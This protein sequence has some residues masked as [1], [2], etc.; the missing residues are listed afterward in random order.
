MSAV[1]KRIIII[2]SI[3][4]GVLAIVGG[5]V[6]VMMSK[7]SAVVARSDRLD[8][9]TIR[10]VEKEGDDYVLSFTYIPDAIGY[11]VCEYNPDTNERHTQTYKGD[12]VIYAGEYVK[13]RITDFLFNT[14]TEADYRDY[15]FTATAKYS[16]QVFN[17]K[18][19]AAY[20]YKNQLKL[21]TPTIKDIDPSATSMKWD[22][23]E[24]ATSYNIY[25]QDEDDSNNDV[26]INTVETYVP[27]STIKQTFGQQENYSLYVV[28]KNLNVNLQGYVLDSEKSDIGFYLPAGKLGD[29]ALS[30][31]KNTKSLS[32]DSVVGA[33]NYL[34]YLSTHGTSAY[35]SL[36]DNAALFNHTNG[37]FTFDLSEIECANYLG[38]VIVY[39]EATTSNAYVEPSTSNKITYINQRKLEGPTDI[40]IASDDSYMQISWKPSVD[41]PYTT[42]YTVWAYKY[43][44][45]Q[46]QN[47]EILA[48]PQNYDVAR[49]AGFDTSTTSVSIQLDINLTGFYGIAIVAK[50]PK[51]SQY[52]DSDV[53]YYK[54]ANDLNFYDANKVLPAPNGIVAN[55]NDD[56]TI[57]VSWNIVE[58]ARRYLVKLESADGNGTPEKIYAVTDTREEINRVNTRIPPYLLDASDLI[59]G[60][61]K[62]SVRTESGVF[63]TSNQ[64]YNTSV[65]Y[66]EGQDY[67]AYRTP[68]DMSGAGLVFI[69]ATK[70]LVWQEILG[71]VSYDV[72]AQTGAEDPTFVG[73]SNS[74]SFNMT[75]FFEDYHNDTGL[76][77]IYI[78]AKGAENAYRTPTKSSTVQYDFVQKYQPPTNLSVTDLGLNS[79]TLE[80]QASVNA[81]TSTTYT[82]IVNDV[83]ASSNA[84]GTSFDITNYLSLGPNIV[85]IKANGDDLRLDSAYASVAFD[86]Y[87]TLTA[88]SGNVNVSASSQNYNYPSVALEFAQVKNA[89]GYY[90][91]INGTHTNLYSDIAVSGGVVTIAL[92]AQDVS[93]LNAFADNEIVVTPHNQDEHGIGNEY[94]LLPSTN[95]GKT[96]IF[97]NTYYL[98]ALA[99]VELL[100]NTLNTN[101]ISKIVNQTINIQ[102][103]PLNLVSAN[104]E[105]TNVVP[106]QTYKVNIYNSTLE[107]IASLDI[108]ITTTERELDGSVIVN[109]FDVFVKENLTSLYTGDIYIA[110]AACVDSPNDVVGLLCACEDFIQINLG[111]GEFSNIQYNETQ[112]G[113]ILSW[114]SVENATSYDVSVAGETVPGIV[115]QDGD[116]QSLD[117][118]TIL[119]DK[120]IGAYNVTITARYGAQSEVGV[121]SITVVKKLFVHDIELID[122]N[123][124]LTI[125]QDALPSTLYDGGLGTYVTATHL[126]LLFDNAEAA[127]LLAT[128][129]ALL[130]DYT[131]KIV[132]LTSLTAVNNVYTISISEFNAVQ[133]C[134]VYAFNN[135]NLATVSDYVVL[136]VG[137]A[138]QYSDPI[139]SL[140]VYEEDIL[141]EWRVEYLDN[142]GVSTPATYVLDIL[143]NDDSLVNNALLSNI[144]L[145]MY[146]NENTQVNAGATI[147][148][149]N[150]KLSISI[151]NNTIRTIVVQIANMAAGNYLFK[152]QAVTQS[153]A[154]ANSSNIVQAEIILAKVLQKPTTR[155]VPY[156]FDVTPSTYHD[157]YDTQDMQNVDIDIYAGYPFR[158]YVTNNTIDN[159][160]LTSVALKVQKN[161]VVV[162]EDKT[163]LLKSNTYGNFIELDKLAMGI[164]TT[165]NYS[166]YL[167]Y[168]T[169][170]AIYYA[171]SDYTLVRTLEVTAC[172][173]DLSVSNVSFADGVTIGADTGFEISWQN[174]ML[175]PLD[176]VVSMRIYDFAGYDMGGTNMP[177]DTV[178]ANQII[179]NTTTSIQYVISDDNQY[180]VEFE[181]Q[182]NITSADE[183]TYGLTAYTNVAYS[184]VYLV[185]NNTKAFS[186]DSVNDTL[187]ITLDNKIALD[188]PIAITL[189]GQE[190]ATASSTLNTIT[191][192][193]GASVIN[194]VQPGLGNANAQVPPVDRLVS[195]VIYK[196]NQV[197][198]DDSIQ[199]FP[200]FVP[201]YA[202]GVQLMNDTQLYWD[203][204]QYVSGYVVHISD[205]TNSY[206]YNVSSNVVSMLDLVDI[207]GGVYYVYV[208][209][210]PLIINNIFVLNGTQN[211]I[212]IEYLEPYNTVSNVSY[213]ESLA[214]QIYDLTADDQDLQYNKTLSW[215][216]DTTGTKSPLNPQTYAMFN[217]VFDGPEYIVISAVSSAVYNQMVLDNQDV[218]SVVVFAVNGAQYSID[219]TDI[220]NN[221]KVGPYAV[222]VVLNHAQIVAQDANYRYRLYSK[223]ST[224]NITNHKVMSIPTAN[225]WDYITVTPDNIVVV[226]DDVQNG[227]GMAK[228]IAG[229]ADSLIARI[230][231]FNHKAFVLSQ[232]FDYATK[233]SIS[234]WT[235]NNSLGNVSINNTQD[236]AGST[237]LII[238]GTSY[239]AIV[240]LYLDENTDD[241]GNYDYYYVPT[242]ADLGT[243]A[244]EVFTIDQNAHTI[245]REYTLNTYY[246][247]ATPTFTINSTEPNSVN[248]VSDAN[249]NTVAITNSNSNSDTTYLINI[250]ENSLS[251]GFN[252]PQ[253]FNRLNNSANSVIIENTGV[254]GTVNLNYVLNDLNLPYGKYW[255]SLVRLSD[256]YINN[257]RGDL[258]ALSSFQSEPVMFDYHYV[259]GNINDVEYSDEDEY[260]LSWT[261]LDVQ[262]VTPVKYYV[263]MQDIQGNNFT[264]WCVVAYDGSDYSI[265]SSSSENELFSINGNKLIFYVDNYVRNTERGGTYYLV[266]NYSYF[267]VATDDLGEV[268]NL[269]RPSPSTP[270]ASNVISSAETTG[271]FVYKIVYP[272]QYT[273]A[274]LNGNTLAWGAVDQSGLA[275]NT[276]THTW[277]YRLENGEFVTLGNV[278][279]EIDNGN[280]T[281][282]TQI[283]LDY[284][285]RQQYGDAIYIR[286]LINN[287]INFLRDTS[288]FNVNVSDQPQLPGFTSFVL[289][290]NKA[291]GTVK[292]VFDNA[293]INNS[294]S[295]EAY[296]LDDLNNGVFEIGLDFELTYNNQ[297]ITLPNKNGDIDL[298]AYYEMITTQYIQL[299][300][301]L[302]LIQLMNTTQ[303]AHFTHTV[304]GVTEFMPGAYKLRLKLYDRANQNEAKYLTTQTAQQDIFI[305]ERWEV[306][307]VELAGPY[308]TYY[309]DLTDENGVFSKRLN[310]QKSISWVSDRTTNLSFDITNPT[311]DAQSLELT[312]WLL[313]YSSEYKANNYTLIVP[314][315]RINR[316]KTYDLS[317]FMTGDQTWHIQIDITEIW[318]TVTLP[319]EYF[320]GFYLGES[321]N[322]HNS[323]IRRKSISSSHNDELNELLG[324]ND[325]TSRNYAIINYKFLPTVTLMDY[326]EYD[327]NGN[328]IVCWLENKIGTDSFSY[329]LSITEMEYTT[330]WTTV[331]RT[332]SVQKIRSET[333]KLDGV[334]YQS[335]QTNKIVDLK[336]AAYYLIKVAVSDNTADSYY[337]GTNQAEDDA[338][339]ESERMYMFLNIYQKPIDANIVSLGT[340]DTT[341]TLTGNDRDDGL[342]VESNKDDNSTTRAVVIVDEDTDPET[343]MLK[344]TFTQES[345]ASLAY[346]LI[347]EDSNGAVVSTYFVGRI[348]NN[349]SL[350]LYLYHNA[351]VQ[352]AYYTTADLNNNAPIYIYGNSVGAIVK[353]GAVYNIT[354]TGLTLNQ[355]FGNNYNNGADYVLKIS[356][357][358][359]VYFHTINSQPYNNTSVGI[360][361][362]INNHN[363]INSRT[364]RYYIKFVVPKID[365]IIL[366][367]KNL[368]TNTYEV[369]DNSTIRNDNGNYSYK[370]KFVIDKNYIG[371]STDSKIIALYLAG[372]TKLEF[373]YYQSYSSCALDASGNPVVEVVVNDTNI[374]G[375]FQKFRQLINNSLPSKLTFGV[376]MLP[377]GEWSNSSTDTLNPKSNATS[378]NDSN[379]LVKNKNINSMVQSEGK[380]ITINIQLPNVPLALHYNNKIEQ[381]AAANIKKAATVNNVYSNVLQPYGAETKVAVD[382]YLGRNTDVSQNNCTR[383]YL[384]QNQFTKR[385]N[386]KFYVTVYNRNTNDLLGS[387]DNFV[388]VVDL[389]DVSTYTS[390]T[391]NLYGKLY[392]LCPSGGAL[393]L[394]VVL[395]Y[396]GTSLG[397]S[398]LWADSQATSINLDFYVRDPSV[399]KLLLTQDWASTHTITYG[400]KTDFLAPMVSIS[401][402]KDDE[403]LQNATL[404]VKMYATYGVAALD[405]YL[406]EISL[407]TNNDLMSWILDKY[408]PRRLNKNDTTKENFL[409]YALIGTTN[410]GAKWHIDYTVKQTS[411]FI[412]SNYLT[413]TL[414]GDNKIVSSN[415]FSPQLKL[416][417]QETTVT[418]SNT[419]G[420]LEKLD[421]DDEIKFYKSYRLYT[422]PTFKNINTTARYLE[423]VSIKDGN[424]VEKL[425]NTSLFISLLKQDDEFAY[426]YTDSTININNR[427]DFVTNLKDTIDTAINKT[428]GVYTISYRYT[429]YG[430]GANGDSA[431]VLPSAKMS[432][433][434]QDDDEKPL[435]FVYTKYQ[436]V[437]Q[438]Y[439]VL[440]V[441]NGVVKTEN[442]T[443]NTNLGTLINQAINNDPNQP[444]GSRQEGSTTSDGLFIVSDQPQTGYQVYIS[445][446][447]YAS[448]KKVYTSLDLETRT[449]DNGSGQDYAYYYIQFDPTKAD[450]LDE[451]DN[452]ANN[453][454]VTGH[455]TRHTGYLQ[456]GNNE[457]CVV[458][459]DMAN[460]NGVYTVYSINGSDITAKHAAVTNISGN[461]LLDKN[462]YLKFAQASGTPN[463]SYIDA[464]NGETWENSLITKLGP[465]GTNAVTLNFNQTCPVC[466]GTG[467]EMRNDL[468]HEYVCTKY[469]NVLTSP[470]IVPIPIAGFYYFTCKY[471]GDQV[472]DKWGLVTDYSVGGTYELGGCCEKR[473]GECHNCGGIGHTNTDSTYNYASLSNG[474]N[475]LGM[476][477]NYQ[478]ISWIFDGEP[479]VDDNGYV[480]ERKIKILCQ[481]TAGENAFVYNT[482]LII[483]QTLPEVNLYTKYRFNVKITYGN[484]NKITTMAFDNNTKYYLCNAKILNN[485][486]GQYQFSLEP[487]TG[488]EGC[489]KNDIDQTEASALTWTS[490]S[491]EGRTITW[492]EKD[493]ANSHVLSIELND[494]APLYVANDYT[495]TNLS[496]YYDMN[497]S[498]YGGTNDAGVFARLTQGEDKSNINDS[499]FPGMRLGINYDVKVVFTKWEISWDLFGWSGSFGDN[500]TCQMVGDET[501]WDG[502]NYDSNILYKDVIND[503]EHILQGYAISL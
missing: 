83:V 265:T 169:P 441:E 386:F 366:E 117:L 333:I 194:A 325:E 348:N 336:D 453:L 421:Y 381:S 493:F 37:K 269:G 148:V 374:E 279:E 52:S 306:E 239:R 462:E 189:N 92:S 454:F 163:Y 286:L 62:I 135:N 379:E 48:A 301:N 475:G 255:V 244:D 423:I 208:E 231:T 133:T 30:Y 6:A 397:N 232:T 206:S 210:A 501:C 478:I 99:S 406:F 19:S 411:G 40:S 213:Q 125:A 2:V 104:A 222:S 282:S 458:S 300:G 179:A 186:Y 90:V 200:V 479:V 299:G 268:V 272:L 343:Q 176:S 368:T 328:T 474:G 384:Y 93:Y 168:P 346:R 330:S 491:R 271:N 47:N 452:E 313:D 267:V 98:P 141:A 188:S 340:N 88:I 145:S 432:T 295:G 414:V 495:Q 249:Q 398:S 407:D 292:Y 228:A 195:V 63:L 317:G 339:A 358:V 350:A 123:T 480:T 86:Y 193:N 259:L 494:K 7:P 360:N 44:A 335:Y 371:T 124:N 97:T 399:Y 229:Q 481:D 422:N 307:N 476:Y 383:A 486:T 310:N 490:T 319:R 178:Y 26:Y 258:Y 463:A 67:V 183:T 262:D 394:D 24:F 437:Y 429:Y 190:F 400:Q 165:G 296:Y 274:T 344:I 290:T 404:Y 341:K 253:N 356:A 23:I 485:Y 321:Q 375:I 409:M 473:R 107:L 438:K 111:I 425:N 204:V 320:V 314:G 382:P 80:W 10:G 370:L 102:F 211:P 294:R 288:G 227:T 278:D 182:T 428:A 237:S 289:D 312:V 354:I 443:Q 166:L 1:A 81:Q 418:Y 315:D 109:I 380:D 436:K 257:P 439:Y 427:D 369:V 196:N 39:V 308:I 159:L 118:Q 11:M 185:N 21:Q 15:T 277:Q 171:D 131:Y 139:L 260:T 70:T 447:D 130:S 174:N 477:D 378:Y 137:G 191:F 115:A 430:A 349:T 82:I 503:E 161:G 460:L 235:G 22:S 132:D 38:S 467:Y 392:A 412:C 66:P 455:Y 415:A 345:I 245:S 13:V 263:T 377:V 205:G 226:D 459:Q 60:K 489:F 352:G 74:T 85:Q 498:R 17:S 342:R 221:S 192:A 309:A 496:T 29:V 469:I 219:L 25:L 331:G 79:R 143:K 444:L 32:W 326:F 338:K 355:L 359:P 499:I 424:N 126:V 246:A 96:V 243:G 41:A 402:T 184:F 461:F 363:G 170:N 433:P 140:S 451:Y 327:K 199:Q 128:S 94:V 45:A 238:N 164:Y 256:T 337:I 207:H 403:T 435:N 284:T 393:R 42:G 95:I 405:E 136:D 12:D 31:D 89:L 68:F 483:G 177:I 167:K 59:P 372:Q 316:C 33:T 419:G 110:V 152:L 311:L 54:N 203:S 53:V 365:N 201:Q 487:K 91:T 466:H 445:Q 347:V 209:T 431:R 4:A 464:S 273:S 16:D 266:G 65:S 14:Y 470:A 51:G 322:N 251:G 162:V 3:L 276:I 112:D 270:S 158:V 214:G 157:E 100:T 101:I 34:V 420:T 283:L 144:D 385:N 220:L 492:E 240:T 84:T 103:T 87:Y 120:T 116:V 446:Y 5:S 413:N 155:F 324:K 442:L 242:L 261:L 456:G 250:Y 390:D 264:Y 500:N 172:E 180:V 149:V 72:Y 217:I 482:K 254:L 291:D 502:S 233:L 35:A 173:Q 215:T 121:Q 58:N 410:E 353:S 396:V 416:V 471:C 318:Q 285:T 138:V 248:G 119:H 106:V 298:T 151:S 304:N 468:P 395:K 8:T 247:L 76:Y 129:P 287:E 225:I 73:V 134:Y 28:A 61:Y 281:C 417:Q 156:D 150:G 202:Q 127:D 234:L 305:V 357:F 154:Y 198:Y 223:P 122:N 361:P 160:T 71:A 36:N 18:E 197:V 434:A 376:V 212:S 175:Y 147:A 373:M 389:L 408:T 78:V 64:E 323:S 43:T 488:F 450:C 387:F 218:S 20:V 391:N 388:D 224:R 27:Y 302:N 46:A 236:A 280:I 187:T 142:N 146:D 153:R 465:G 69:P 105:F 293:V 216:I 275:L 303:K 75:T 457:F 367:Q 230:D 484:S 448:N 9:P 49:S 56:G 440:S 50:A 426:T 364:F 449:F 334:I 114:D 252:S 297:T 332:Y 362:K 329:D 77:N 57:W 351:E 113:M 55:E 241:L 181:I 401:A 497:A 472:N 108:D